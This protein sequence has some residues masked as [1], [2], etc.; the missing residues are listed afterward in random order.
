MI[1]ELLN[2]IMKKTIAKYP[3]IL[4]LRLN[5]ILLALIRPRALLEGSKNSTP[6]G[7]LGIF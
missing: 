3:G 1:T 4:R 2:G 6:L 5:F 7:P